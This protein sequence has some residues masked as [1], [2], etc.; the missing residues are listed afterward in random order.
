MPLF[1][2]EQGLR[3]GFAHV[4]KRPQ[5][6]VSRASLASLRYARDARDAHCLLSQ[7]T[8]TPVHLG[9]GNIVCFANDS[10]RGKAGA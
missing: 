10:L 6:I 1:W 8:Y 4:A 2:K 7:R 9:L 3:G 5:P